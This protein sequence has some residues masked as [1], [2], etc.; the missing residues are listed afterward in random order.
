MNKSYVVIARRYRPQTFDDIVSQ[1]YITTTL[2]NAIIENKVAHAYIFSGSRGVGKTSLAR[3][4]AKA[5]NCK[6]GPTSSPCNKCE[7]C[8]SITKGNDPDVIEIDAA[9]QTGIEDIRRLQDVIAYVPLRARFKV[10]IMDEAHQLSKSSFNALLKTIEEPPPHVKFIFAT[11]APEKLPETII[12]RC[13]RFNFRPIPGKK[14][15]QHLVKICENEKFSCE[16]TILTTIAKLARGS[17]RDAQSLLDLVISSHGNEASARDLGFLVDSVSADKIFSMVDAIV[18]YKLDEIIT[19]ID[20]IFAEGRDINTLVE[21]II[22]HFWSLILVQLSSSKIDLLEQEIIENKEALHAQSSYFK[23]ETL[24]EFIALLQ[25]TKRNIKETVNDRLYLEFTCLKL[26]KLFKEQS[27]DNGLSHSGRKNDVMPERLDLSGKKKI[28]N[29]DMSSIDAKTHHNSAEQNI[30]TVVFEEHT[31]QDN[32]SV[33]EEDSSSNTAGDFSLLTEN[34]KRSLWTKILNEIKNTQ[35]VK[36][37]PYIKEG[38]FIRADREEIVIGFPKIY[39]YHR[40]RLEDISLKQVIENIIEKTSGLKISLSFI[41]ISGEDDPSR[42]EHQW[43]NTVKDGNSI[44]NEPEIKKIA[45]PNGLVGQAPLQKP[46]TEKEKQPDLLSNSKPVTGS[47]LT[48][49]IQSNNLITDYEKKKQIKEKMLQDERV[50]KILQ[51]FEGK[52]VDVRES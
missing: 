16:P 14:I 26:A 2:K 32:E 19:N 22:E 37:Y 52:I 28:S 11:T 31:L 27:V 41:A 49:T 17:M 15:H 20:S 46:I 18:K 5:L 40:L 7:F 30:S 42:G 45:R 8:Q 36:I 10:Y 43:S 4:F 48:K 23:I 39:N 12:S 38:Q 21:Q 44:T 35:P 33:V 6:E 47:E 24:I 3:I 34:D 25:D 50:G 51:V 9:S 1:E 13:Q 29:V